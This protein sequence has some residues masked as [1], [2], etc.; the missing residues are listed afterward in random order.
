AGQPRLVVVGAEAGVDE[1][2]LRPAFLGDEQPARVEVRLGKD[3]LFQGGAVPQPH[4]AAAGK[5]LVPDLSQGG[6]TG[7]AEASVLVHEGNLSTGRGPNGTASIPV[8]TAC[9]P[10]PLRT[11]IDGA[12]RHAS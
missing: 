10:F 11:I 9:S 7:G 1:T 3:V 4:R 12:D 8:R 6:R 2:D 5:R